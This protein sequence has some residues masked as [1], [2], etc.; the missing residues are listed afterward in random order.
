MRGEGNIRKGRKR[1]LTA[2]SARKKKGNMVGREKRGNK[3]DKAIRRPV[4]GRVNNANWRVK[5]QST[6]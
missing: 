1:V 5:K 2:V 3:W 6:H 4:D